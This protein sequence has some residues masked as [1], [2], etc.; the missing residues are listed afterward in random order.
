MSFTVFPAIDL[1]QGRCVRLRQ[2]DPQAM[3]VYS[4]DPVAVAR[5]WVA[6]GASWLHVVNLD[7]AFNPQGVLQA[8]SPNLQA[9]IAIREAVPVSIQF[10]GGVRSLEDVAWVLDVGVDRVVL[11]TVALTRPDVVREAVRQ[12]GPERIVVGLD[13]R[14]GRVASHG[15]QEVSDV[16]VVTLGRA[17]YRAGVRH[18]LYTDIARDGMLSGVDAEATARVAEETGLSVIASGGVAGLEDV[19]ALVAVAHRGVEGVVIGQAL[20][21]GRVSLRE[22]LRWLD[23]AANPP[24]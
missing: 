10:G 9:L 14:E 13:A 12:F 11:G 22:I 7:G 2:G 19:Q 16:R 20:Y 6:Q 21:T 23:R 1:R 17:M 3:T 5:E 8:P 15:W 24:A 18:A 4:D